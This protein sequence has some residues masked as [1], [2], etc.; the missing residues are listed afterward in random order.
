MEQRN[1][2]Q[3]HHKGKMPRRPML[4]A[5]IAAV[6][7][8]IVLFSLVL[9]CANLTID[10]QLNG[11]TEPVTVVFGKEQYLEKGA[12]ATADGKQ[13]DVTID[14]SVDST[15]LGVY[16]I[17]YRAKYLWLTASAER[18]VRV[19]DTTAPVI[20]LKTNEDYFTKPGEPYEEEGFTAT[21]DYDGDITAN[22]E[23]TE[24]DGKVTYKV[25][26]SSGNETMIV[27]PIKYA[28]V[29]APEI[30]LKGETSLTLTAGGTYT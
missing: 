24:A 1:R 19:V 2:K 25:K 23:R 29:V 20:E 13:L 22:V 7:A 27:R 26:D 3:R 18:E 12:T 8:A 28:D 6:A 11:G 15:K 16:K 9:W 17:I 5:A 30:V 4:I 21:D 14:G 10:L